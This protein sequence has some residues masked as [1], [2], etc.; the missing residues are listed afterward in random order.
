MKPICDFT[1]DV[2]TPNNVQT[3]RLFDLSDNAP[4]S[5]QWTINPT[6]FSFQNATTAT[7][8]NID[9]KF[10]AFGMYS[11]T[12][13]VT[14][15]TVT[16]QK[17]KTNYITLSAN[18]NRVL[19]KSFVVLFPNPATDKIS[20]KGIE[21]ISQVSAMASNGQQTQLS[22]VENEIDITKLS[23]GIYFITIKDNMDGVYQ[24]KLVVNR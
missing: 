19:N 8:K 13:K 3:V 11:V 6:T 12:L 10:S 23:A 1:A 17:T 4:T 5:W 20:V 22:F 24:T 16:D 21:Y 7:S 14:N 9:V 18:A 2:V 15:T